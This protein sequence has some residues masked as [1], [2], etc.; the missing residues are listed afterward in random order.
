MNWNL[1]IFHHLKKYLF[2]PDTLAPK[3]LEI[4]FCSTFL[5]NDSF[6][7]SISF[8]KQCIHFKCLNTT[9][10]KIKHHYDSNLRY[11][12]N[13]KMVIL[14]IFHE[15]TLTGHQLLHYPLIL[16]FKQQYFWPSRN[17]MLF[18]LL[19]SRGASGLG[20]KIEI[21]QAIYL[22]DSLKIGM[23]FPNFIR[24]HVGSMRWTS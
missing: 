24:E 19:S 17:D 13:F 4:F 18:G 8:E 6:E 1:F 3:A 22:P 11:N 21:Q 2:L 7:V 14:I 20:Q 23:S 9:E 10:E 16:V 12:L 5:A 15:A